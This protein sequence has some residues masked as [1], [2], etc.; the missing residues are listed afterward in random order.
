MRTTE[1]FEKRWN[2]IWLRWKRRLQ[3]DEEDRESA[4]KQ[5]QSSR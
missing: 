2:V 4:G 5:L 1:G 3:G